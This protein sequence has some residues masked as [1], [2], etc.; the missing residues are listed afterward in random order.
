MPSPAELV[1]GLRSIGCYLENRHF[2]LVS[3]KH[4][5]TYV[6]V[7]VAMMD[8][9][10]RG[11]FASALADSLADDRPSGLY[12]STVGGLLLASET[13][14]AM[15][16]PLLIGAPTAR[17]VSIVNLDQFPPAALARLVV[18]DDVLTTGGTI[19]TTLD[20]LREIPGVG[21]AGIRV[22]VDRSD[23][24]VSVPFG[25]DSFTVRGLCR[26]PLRTYDPSNCPM[27]PD[28]YQNLS[29]PEN[30]FVSVAL[31]MP[32]PSKWLPMVFDGYRVVFDLQRDGAQIRELARW[33]PW[34]PALLEG[35]PISR[36]TEDSGL[37]QF[38][39]AIGVR[40]SRFGI[41]SSVV[42]ELV[43]RLLTLPHVRV[44]ARSLGCSILL[45][46]P[47]QLLA[48]LHAS[49][50]VEVPIGTPIGE[51]VP[52]LPYFDALLE[53]DAVFVF[54]RDGR[55]AGARRL[56]QS[57]PHGQAVGPQLIRTLTRQVEAIGLVVRRGRTAVSTYSDGSLASIAELSEKTGLWEFTTP[58]PVVGQVATM[59]PEAAGS[60]ESVLEI[61]REMVA[62][63]Y[64][65]MFVVGS[66]LSKIK[67]QT[68]KL[69]LARRPLELLGSR[70]VA[71]IA[72]LDGAVL[73]NDRSEVEQATVIIENSETAAASATAYRQNSSGGARRQAALRTSLEC[74]SVAVVFVSQN[75]AIEIYVRG[76]SFP[77]A[78]SMSGVT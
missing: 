78:E 72:K 66:G 46:D 15:K 9:G 48:Q 20:P 2:K 22:A 68:P 41:K 53:E 11:A 37:A 44:E 27:C 31:A 63:G 8:P 50:A 45:G 23:S 71:E 57:L 19:L 51:W 60:L 61:A 76:E 16:L 21:L 4:S 28:P 33:E 34:L 67:Y 10:M 5:E 62:L 54:D 73:I 12:A 14:K 7:R 69:R 56:V 25:T 26:V 74:P 52:L 30:D 75:G 49:V 1:D 43:G 6:Q 64:G 59:V 70:E 40:T 77:V 47:D 36:I 17:V 55:L 18:V 3:G 24:D 13:A 32:A 65:G 29:D 42:T 39:Q 38:I 35:L 58:G